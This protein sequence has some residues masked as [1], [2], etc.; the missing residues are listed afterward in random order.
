MSLGHL[1]SDH[2]GPDASAEEVTLGGKGISPNSSPALIVDGDYL[3]EGG[4]ILS[5][6]IGGTDSASYAQ[7]QVGGATTL[8]DGAILDLNFVNGFAPHTGDTFS[9]FTSGSM[10]GN[11]ATV[12]IEGLASG[13]QYNLA[14]DGKG[15]L[16]LIALNDGRPTITLKAGARGVNTVGLT[17]SGATSAAIDVYRN[18]A[19][20]RT[21]PNFG[22]Y[23]D[24]TGGATYTYQVCEAGT[25]TCSSTVTATLRH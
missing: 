18:N 20:I 21:V 23:I 19:L 12:T 22:R 3:Q 1:G 8:M 5:L 13:F 9:L 11:F 2:V 6:D 10:T 7:V 16:Q 25:A 14:Q 15:D 17:W 24:Y 4:G